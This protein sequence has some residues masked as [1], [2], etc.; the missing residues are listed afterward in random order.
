LL[1]V[2]L[3]GV[4]VFGLITERDNGEYFQEKQECDWKSNDEA[5]SEN[6]Q[7]KW[8]YFE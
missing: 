7:S 2:S 5:T 3:V 8:S 4:I 6:H 1:L